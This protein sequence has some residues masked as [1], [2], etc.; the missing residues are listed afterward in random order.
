MSALEAKVELLLNGANAMHDLNKTLQDQNERLEEQQIGLQA[1]LR[2][3]QKRAIRDSSHTRRVERRL[4]GEESAST[5]TPRFSG[6]GLG[7][8]PED[9]SPKANAHVGHDLHKQKGF[10][11][12]TNAFFATTN[13]G[14]L[15]AAMK[16]MIKGEMGS[17]WDRLGKVEKTYNPLVPYF[18]KDEIPLPYSKELLDSVIIGDTKAPKI[19]LYEGLTDPYDHLDSFRYA[20][21]GKGQTRPP[22][23]GSSRP[24]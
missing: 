22:N 10:L 3:A 21:E 2:K 9:V 1:N 5:H 11:T 20:M 19:A 24:P 13:E 4:F 18:S 17:L 12:E 14:D 7:P 15:R 16:A 8:D 6:T 23:A